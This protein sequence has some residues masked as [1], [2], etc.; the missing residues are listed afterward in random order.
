VSL[1]AREILQ[2]ASSIEEAYQIAA[3]RKMFVSESILIGS[4]TDGRSAIIEKSPHR[5]GLFTPSGNTLVCANHFQGEAF[6]DDRRN[7]EN[8]ESSDSRLRF[9]RM[10]ELLLRNTRIDIDDAVRI[11]RDR[12][13]PGGIDPGMGNPMAIN[14]LIA[15]HSVVFKPSELI[16]WVSSPPFQLGKYVAYDLN[17][18]FS[19]TSSDIADNNEIYTAGL[20]IPADTFLFSQEYRNYENFRIMTAELKLLQREKLPLPEGFEMEYSA[21]NPE[22]YSAWSGL[23]DYWFEK[24]E[25]LRAWKYYKSALEREIPGNE[26]LE[27]LTR[28]AEESLTRSQNAKNR[29]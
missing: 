25:Y 27:K 16:A 12:M 9:E 11:L 4:L 20:T 8:I 19:L 2:Y 18:V 5:H 29:D 23:A 13:G 10:N 7:T 3:R 21:L 1:V 15:H 28:L 6:S 17:K 26:T 22:L 14:Q 24:G